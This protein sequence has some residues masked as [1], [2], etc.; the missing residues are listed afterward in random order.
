LTLASMP[1]K[2][3]PKKLYRSRKNRV[4]AGV[5]GGLA[6]YMHLDPV[7]LRVV[8]FVA[9]LGTG[10]FPVALIYALLA[11][12]VPEAPLPGAPEVVDEQ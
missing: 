11:V 4:I 9:V 3:R 12:Y 8:T 2:Q 7:L 1:R 10:F 6:E 5:C